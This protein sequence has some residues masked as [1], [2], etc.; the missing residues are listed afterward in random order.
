MQPQ[1][2]DMYF[3][4]EF[5]LCIVINLMKTFSSYRRRRQI[6]ESKARL[7]LQGH[8]QLCISFLVGPSN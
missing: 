3:D 5:Y 1:I 4:V 2:Q 7:I 8:L 6:N